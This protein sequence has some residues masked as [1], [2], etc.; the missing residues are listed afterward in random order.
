MTPESA[1][2]CE[3]LA[4]AV[5]W[6]A[7]AF[8]SDR[9]AKRPGFGTEALYRGVVLVGGLLLGGVGAPRGFLRLWTVSGPVGWA[10]AA[11]A[12]LGF[13][14]CWWARIH[15]GRL[16]SGWVTKKADHRIV[17]TGPYRI[18]RHPIYTGMLTAVF[19]TAVDKGTAGALA[20]A[21]A[22]TAG[23]WIKARLEEKFLSEELGAEAYSG[24]RS[25]VPMLLPFF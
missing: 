14:F 23:F 18:V 9:A 3:W 13:L 20:G 5:S 25:R 7:A 16:W 17:H 19:A 2:G 21:A 4:W 6:M 10:L 11:A 8:W 1:I 24:Y 22:M 12:G 15:L